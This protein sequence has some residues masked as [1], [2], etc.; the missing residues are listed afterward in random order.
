L[1]RS[2]KEAMVSL[3]LGGTT[4]YALHYAIPGKQLML[5][6]KGS[7]FVKDDIEKKK[8]V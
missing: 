5:I 4:Y 3:F 7:D 8:M 2:D 6:A 1:N